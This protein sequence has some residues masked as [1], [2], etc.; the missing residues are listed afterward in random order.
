MRPNVPFALLLPG[1]LA[2]V[3]SFPSSLSGQEAHLLIVAGLGGEPHYQESFVE[4]GERMVESALAAGVAPER[5]TF[6]AEDPEASPERIEARSTREEVEAALRR[7]EER[8]APDDRVLLLLI[9]HGSGSGGESLVN[10]PG[11]SLQATDYSALLDNLAPRQIAIVNTASASGDF[12]PVLAGEGRIVITATRSSQQRNATIFGQYFVEAF[13]TEGADFDRDGRISLLEAFEYAR[14]ET[15]RHFRERNL[16]PSETALLEDR[17]DGR[18]ISDPGGEGEV[19]L[20]ASRF[21]LG[22]ETDLPDSPEPGDDSPLA[23][24]LEAQERLEADVRELSRRADT[25][26]PGEYRE[27]MESLLVE[28][29]RIGQEIRRLR[30]DPE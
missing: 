20:L 16:L 5:V 4:W 19:G 17:P 9:G 15:E 24:L 7:I 30:E 18:G 13:S 3:S 26:E 1:L 11:P 25:L 2:G 6:L 8:S 14:I 28:L 10:L 12:I 29:A 23:E 27:R 21:F 22:V